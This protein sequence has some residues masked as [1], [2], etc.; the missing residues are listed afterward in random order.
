MSTDFAS[1]LDAHVISVQHSRW[2]GKHVWPEFE[3]SLCPLKAGLLWSN[4]YELV[5]SGEP[6][7]VP[8]EGPCGE[9]VEASGQNALKF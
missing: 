1:F 5:F 3:F 4:F 6:L 7:T 9:Q 8:T 2:K